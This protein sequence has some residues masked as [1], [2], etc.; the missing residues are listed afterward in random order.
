MGEG[1]MSPADLMAMMGNTNNGA[2][3]WMNNPFIWFVFLALFGNGGFAGFGGGR[4]AAAE[5]ELT[6]AEMMDGFNNQTLQSDLKGIGAAMT[7][8]FAD[9]NIT[10]NANAN[11]I[12][13]NLC[14]LSSETQMGFC[15]VNNN[16]GSLKYEM[17]QNC[18]DI[19]NAVHAEGE[20]TRALITQNTIQDLRD[21][22]AEKDNTLQSAQLALANANQTQSILNSLGRFVPYAGTSPCNP[23]GATY[24]TPCCAN[25]W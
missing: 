8:G 20:T 1:T 3:A 24:N 10:A 11:M 18:C 13:H 12:N 14:N 23:C 6:R 21:K 7:S 15:S 16:I 19:K 25:N 5:A 2:N 4:S 9:A 17:A 22:L